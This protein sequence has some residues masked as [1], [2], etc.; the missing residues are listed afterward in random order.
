VSYLFFGRRARHTA[1]LFALLAL[2]FP[3]DALAYLDPGTGSLF[4]Q[5]VIATLAAVAYGVR[6]YWGRIRALWRRPANRGRPD[7]ER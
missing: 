3:S 2:L 7:P 5:T 6:L 4:V 1:F